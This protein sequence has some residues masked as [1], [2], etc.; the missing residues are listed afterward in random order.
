M[1][2]EVK[3]LDKY[4]DEKKVL[5]NISFSLSEGEITGVV[6]RNGS[7]KTTLLKIMSRILDPSKG[8]VSVDLKDIRMYPEEITNIAFLPDNFYFFNYERIK[9]VMEYY[10][11]LF[12]EFDRSF[13]ET[14][15]KGLN[16]TL[17]QPVKSL[18]KGNKT[19]LGLIMV[20]A[21]GAK[22]ILVD[23]VLDGIDV[24]N[25]EIIIRYLLDAKE[26]GR[27][28][29][30]ASHQLQELQNI[31]DRVIYLSL[32]G[33]IEGYSNSRESSFQKVQV[34]VKDTL[35]EEIKNGSYIRSH[36]GRVYN[37]LI[38]GSEQE[39]VEKLAIEEIVQ[40]DI[41][42]IQLEDYFFWEKKGEVSNEKL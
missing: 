41:L 18:S 34:V 39:V 2:L 16:I 20:L 19:I 32:D 33:K 10:Q 38:D 42:P 13:V 35:P 29:F 23:E 7:G 15:I 27:S 9:E 31:C 6:G 12:P 5:E 22:F 28:V 4:F 36:I 17:N 21:T 30:I 40:F 24:L 8:E 11:I 1:I 26:N 3:N 14:E 25:K 37:I